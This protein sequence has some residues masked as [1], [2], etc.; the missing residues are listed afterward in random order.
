MRCA[1]IDVGSNS[2][3]L[4]V[5]DTAVGVLHDE[6]RVVGLGK[7]LGDGGLFREDRMAAAAEALSDYVATA[8]RLGVPA[9][10]VVACATSGARRARNAAAFFAEQ[11]ARLGLT[12]RTI[13]GEEEARLSFIGAT[14]GL[15]LPDGPI[16]VLDLGGGSTEVVLG[17][18]REGSPEQTWRTSLEIGSVRLTEQHL[19]VGLVDPAD[20][21]RLQAAVRAAFS[22]VPP[23]QGDIVVIAVAG[24][25]TSLAAIDLGLARYNGDR[26]HGH[27]L[28]RAALEAI[29]QRLLAADPEQRRRIAA[30]SPERADYLLAGATVLL[31]GLERLGADALL[32]SD[33]G[34]RFGILAEEVSNV[35]L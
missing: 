20:L 19:G 23:H 33:R 22:E 3:L 7:G 28:G 18:I 31:G 35:R 24:T 6:A 10:R 30:V 12:I 27:V 13:S 15:P 32:L 21:A 26:V 8:A 1:A 2:L 17:T 9:E 34:L 25:A 29:A 14:G 16:A 5:L 4:T 11:E